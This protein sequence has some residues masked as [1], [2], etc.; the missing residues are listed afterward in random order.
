[1]LRMGICFILPLSRSLIELL[2]LSTVVQCEYLPSRPI[3]TVV[4]GISEYRLIW[5]INS[6]TDIFFL[7]RGRETLIDI[8]KSIF[9]FSPMQKGSLPVVHWL[10]LFCEPQAVLGNCLNVHKAYAGVP[11][12]NRFWGALFHL[13]LLWWIWHLQNIHI[14]R[15][16]L[17]WWPPSI[18]VPSHY[19]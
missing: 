13:R 2:T 10:F 4:S 15:W 7:N 6:S 17:D 12:G 18:F 11:F 9:N 19:G 3:K 8:P 16:T 14:N 1:M 5:S